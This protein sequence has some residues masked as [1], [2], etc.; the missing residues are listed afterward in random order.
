[1]VG[2][3]GSSPIA[4]T[5]FGSGIKG[6]ANRQALG[7][8]RYEKSTKKRDPGAIALGRGLRKRRQ[9]QVPGEFFRRPARKPTARK[10][11]SELPR[12]SPSRM[13]PGTRPEKAQATAATA[14]RVTI[15]AAIATVPSWVISAVHR[16]P[17]MPSHRPSIGTA[18]Q[19]ASAAQS[20]DCRRGMACSW[21]RMF[22]MTGWPRLG[23]DFELAAR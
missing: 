18:Q 19:A 3:V 2:V 7:L 14:Q 21:Y 20:K 1:M 13:T 6:L 10:S 15:A 22:D 17:P 11:C 16:Q 4:P 5:K 9:N 8:W 23:A 12:T